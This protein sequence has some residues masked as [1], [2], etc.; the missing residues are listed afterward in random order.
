MSYVIV[1]TILTYGEEEV[2]IGYF[3]IMGSDKGV[4]FSQEHTIQIP[5]LSTPLTI[6][7]NIFPTILTVFLLAL[8]IE[9]VAFISQLPQKFHLP[10]HM[11]AELICLYYQQNHHQQNSALGG[12]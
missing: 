8:C 4:K 5:E 3:V 10:T 9:A 12:K 6:C 7:A 2:H 1:K 11:M